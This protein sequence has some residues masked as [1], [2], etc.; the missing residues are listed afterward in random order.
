MGTT[1]GCSIVFEPA[2]F[3]LALF[4][5]FTIFRKANAGCQDELLRLT[6]LLCVA[7]E[8]TGRG[9][10][11]WLG[12]GEQKGPLAEQRRCSRFRESVLAQRSVLKLA[13]CLNLSTIL[14]CRL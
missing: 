3:M 10:C 7:G 2:D 11:N 6:L 1:V 14:G 12:V 8:H 4:N 9:S 5:V 13:H